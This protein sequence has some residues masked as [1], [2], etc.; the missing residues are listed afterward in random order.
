MNTKNYKYNWVKS[1]RFPN[2][3]IEMFKLVLCLGLFL[4]K[5]EGSKKNVLNYALISMTYKIRI[6]I[7]F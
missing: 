1:I 6:K 5:G 7:N 2:R 4:S 3:S